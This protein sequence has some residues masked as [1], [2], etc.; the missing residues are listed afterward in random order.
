MVVVGV[1]RHLSLAMGEAQR[2]EV[3]QAKDVV[4]VSVGI[5]DSIDIADA[6]AQCLMAEI[7]PGVDEYAMRRRGVAVLPFDGDGGTEAPVAWIGGG[8]DAAGAAQRGH[9]HGGAA[10]EKQDAGVDGQAD[11]LY[12]DGPSSVSRK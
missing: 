11:V 2:A 9:A 10:A 8:A 5:E 6:E 12:Q 3:I 1:E 7:R 4:S